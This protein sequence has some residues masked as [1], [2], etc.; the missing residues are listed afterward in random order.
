M[1]LHA[2]VAAVAVAA[3]PATAAAAAAA[4]ASAAASM[5]KEVKQ[6]IE[7]LLMQYDV[8]LTSFVHVT[9]LDFFIHVLHYW[10]CC[11]CLQSCWELLQKC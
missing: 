8:N 5:S 3:A 1:K 10:F 4:A 7:S 2:A 11:Y 9:A 6:K